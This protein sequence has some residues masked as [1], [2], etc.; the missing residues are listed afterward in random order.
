MM[1]MVVRRRLCWGGLRDKFCIVS[2]VLITS[3]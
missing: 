3:G 1:L 2:N